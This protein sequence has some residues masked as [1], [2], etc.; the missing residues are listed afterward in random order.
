MNIT[1]KYDLKNNRYD[2]LIMMTIVSV[3]FAGP[4]FGAFIPTRIIGFL[5]LLYYIIKI[6]VNYRIKK[7][8]YCLYGVI[9]YSF[10]AVF[11]I[12]DWYMYTTSFLSLLCYIGA[13]F[14][15]YYSSFKASKP[16]DSILKGWL[17][18]Q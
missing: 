9:F 12:S 5:F 13:F 14:L 1:I 7:L 8:T 11:W 10:L 3:I 4:L 15:I 16:I 6:K 17:F 18:L 2:Y